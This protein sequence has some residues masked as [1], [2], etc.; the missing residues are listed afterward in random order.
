MGRDKPSIFFPAIATEGQ[1]QLEGTYTWHPWHSGNLAA[2]GTWKLPNGLIVNVISPEHP[3]TSE[4]RALYLTL[5]G[6]SKNYQLFGVTESTR[7]E[8][9][10]IW[11][12]LSCSY[13]Q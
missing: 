12:F 13:L 8:C 5:L 2:N 7:F 3:L 11:A 1:A 4:N 6:G 10:Y 9:K